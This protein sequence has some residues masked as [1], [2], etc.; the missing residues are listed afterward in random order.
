[1]FIDLV[2]RI[3]DIDPVTV[4]P[5]TGFR[6]TGWH[7]V[8]RY[9]SDTNKIECRFW[10]PPCDELDASAEGF[11]V[12]QIRSALDVAENPSTE[13]EG[14]RVESGQVLYGTDLKINLKRVLRQADLLESDEGGGN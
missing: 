3:Y 1:M 2:Q 10:L 7:R 4:G 12:Q 9:N 14:H 5:F 11:E 13:T 8:T 6:F